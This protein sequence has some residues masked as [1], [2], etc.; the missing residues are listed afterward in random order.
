MISPVK[1]RIEQIDREIEKTNLQLE[2]KMQ[3]HFK[4]ELAYHQWRQKQYDKIAELGE[5]L[6]VLQFPEDYAELPVSWAAEELGIKVGEVNHLIAVS[7]IFVSRT[8]EYTKQDF[9]GRDEI[10][11]ILDYGV[12]KMLERGKQEPE[13]IFVEAI[14]FVR[15]NDLEGFEKA[16][17]RLTSRDSRFSIRAEAIETVINLMKGNLEDA[18]AAVRANFKYTAWED[19]TVYLTYL[20]RLIR[21]LKLEEH[22]AQAFVEQILSITEKQTLRL[23]DHYKSYH[24]KK[25]AKQMDDQQKSAM[26][27]TTAVVRALKKYKHAQQFKFYIERHSQMRDEEFE[28]IIRNAIFTV[29]QAESTYS[30][31]SASK[32]FVDTLFSEIPKWYSPADVLEHIPSETASEEEE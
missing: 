7:E 4:T 30:E 20:G 13:D 8:G 10:G 14:E 18:L 32:L 6:R 9:I 3:R 2:N 28:G 17:D 5:E 1:K 26:F 29:L 24:A 23:Y 11:R 15:N 25:P 31:S 19:L 12:E 22:G 21:H 27:L 16:H